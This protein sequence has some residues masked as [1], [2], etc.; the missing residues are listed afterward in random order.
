MLTV[1]YADDTAYLGLMLRSVS[2]ESV[3]VLLSLPLEPLEVL[4]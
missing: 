3:G 1:G 2:S 4:G